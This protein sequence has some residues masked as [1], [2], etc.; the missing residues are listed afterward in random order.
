MSHKQNK[1]A[2]PL[3]QGESREASHEK[4]EDKSTVLHT[5]AKKSEEDLRKTTNPKSFL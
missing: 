4:A 3:C 1:K 2:K 5:G